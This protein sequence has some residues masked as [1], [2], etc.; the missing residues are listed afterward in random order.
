MRELRVW[1]VSET[2][3][4]YHS[5]SRVP[6]HPIAFALRFYSFNVLNSKHCFI[7]LSKFPALP[8]FQKYHNENSYT[9]QTNA[10]YPFQ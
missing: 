8:S 2:A 6:L 7:S 10:T 3:S 9:L 4:I 1:Y 5:L